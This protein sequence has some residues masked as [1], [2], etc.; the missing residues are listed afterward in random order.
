VA[1]AFLKQLLQWQGLEDHV[2]VAITG[3]VVHGH[4]VPM[5][6]PWCTVQR[7]RRLWHSG[8]AWQRLSTHLKTQSNLLD[9]VI[10]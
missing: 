5:C 9:L 1:T 8:D 6:L 7:Q 4:Q 3:E 2:Q 10:E